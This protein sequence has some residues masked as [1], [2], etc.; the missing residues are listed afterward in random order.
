MISHV[1]L[2]LDTTTLMG[3]GP[4]LDMY[5]DAVSILITL[6]LSLGILTLLSLLLGDRP[7]AYDESATR[8]NLPVQERE[9]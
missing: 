2:L 4:W 3:G 9:S 6:L 5:T 1:G 7:P 8:D